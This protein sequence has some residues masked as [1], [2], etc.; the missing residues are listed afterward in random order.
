ML[1]PHL[2]GHGATW[3]MKPRHGVQWNCLIEGA[4]GPLL[5]AS[6]YRPDR[7]PG[8]WTVPMSSENSAP[9]AGSRCPS[10]SSWSRIADSPFPASEHVSR[11]RL[12]V[13]AT[14]NAKETELH[15]VL[16]YKGDFAGTGSSGTEPAD[17]FVGGRRQREAEKRPHF[18]LSPR[19]AL[20]GRTAHQRHR[21]RFEKGRVL[22]LRDDGAVDQL[23]FFPTV[24]LARE[25]QAVSELIGREDAA[26]NLPRPVDT[27]STR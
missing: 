14:Y 7:P 22:V 18:R 13:I 16:F 26:E 11:N 10:R 17:E 3:V 12:S 1:K 20:P 2:I 15:Y 21:L 24:A 6:C 19:G 5:D 9:T 23:R 27:P 8:S 25:P 4:P